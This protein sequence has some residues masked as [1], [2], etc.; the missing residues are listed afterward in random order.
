LANKKAEELVLPSTI[1]LELGRIRREHLG[2]NGFQG[3][4]ATTFN[5][6][7]AWVK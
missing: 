3:G 5:V 2:D 4:A 6:T 7:K 1:L